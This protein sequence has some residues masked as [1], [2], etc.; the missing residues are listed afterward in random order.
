MTFRH[1]TDIGQNF[2]IDKSVVEWMMARA[3]LGPCDRVLEIG[4]GS[5]ILTKGILESGCAGL[6]AIEIDTRL[7]EYLEPIAAADS[8]LALHWGDAVRFDYAALARSPT[9]VIANLPYHIT[10]PVLWK[11]FE[12]ASENLSYML[13][14]TQAEAALRLSC[15]AGA[16]E[17]NP[18]SITLS[19]MGSAEVARKVSRTAFRPAPR[20]DSAI[21][22]IRFAAPGER[23]GLPNGKIWRRLLSGSF[24][25]RRKTLVNNWKA[26]FGMTRE[27]ALETLA[28]HSLGGMSRPEE[29]SLGDWLALSRDENMAGH[30]A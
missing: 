27:L 2:L 24:A 22:E 15:G 29:L 10:T 12:A 28:K 17:S 3:G 30:I 6:D 8:R 14:M 26:S 5:G 21:V 7:K 19:A 23:R 18:L 4:P 13:V 9:H 1:N 16:R 25:T 11:L 20:V